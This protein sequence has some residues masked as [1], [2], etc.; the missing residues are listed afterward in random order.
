MWLERYAAPFDWVSRDGTLGGILSTV[1]NPI[2][3]YPGVQT[4][5][6]ATA[7]AA[8]IDSMR[9]VSQ[10]R[11]EHV[12][13]VR[14]I[15]GGFAVES[16]TGTHTYHA[17]LVATGTRRSLP[18]IVGVDAGL[19]SWIL[20]STA[21]DPEAFVDR[22]VIMIGGG[23]A[24]VEGALNALDAGASSVTIASRSG[25]RAQRQFVER[26]Q[27]EPHATVLPPPASP[28]GFERAG[29]R[30]RVLLEGGRAIEGD[31]V[32]IRIGVEPVR[33]RLE[34]QPRL[35]ERGFIVVDRRGETDVAGLF[36]AGDVTSTPLR[37]IATSVG[38][39]TRAARS[40]A[41]I[42]GIWD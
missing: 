18:D 10:P 29:E 35:D 9:V 1:Y 33:P 19:G 25:L 3:D 26:L 4:E 36:A 17:V 7:L 15:D 12:K 13:R 16:D 2:I 38:D 21:K 14:A 41:E 20:T 11:V 39:G 32:V 23:D 40:I 34:P 8:I 31:L 6:G 5:T 27:T 22:D 28:I 30:C 24:A 42:L 37:S